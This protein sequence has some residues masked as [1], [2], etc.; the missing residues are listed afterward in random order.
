[1]QH[2]ADLEIHLDTDDYRRHTTPAGKR[3]FTRNLKFYVHFT[4]TS[5]C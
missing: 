4:L 5:T 1:M 3:W 2:V